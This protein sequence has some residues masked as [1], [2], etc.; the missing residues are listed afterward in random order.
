M[1][2]LVTE[3]AVIVF[4]IL[5]AFGV[6]AW[7]D[8]YQARSSAQAYVE[9]VGEELEV[10]S[11]RIDR[12]IRLARVVEDA[13]PKPGLKVPRNSRQTHSTPSSVAW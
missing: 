1:R 11:G 5:V 3:S 6:D 2:R 8:N 10:I 4:S 13:P 9:A 12:S 7:W